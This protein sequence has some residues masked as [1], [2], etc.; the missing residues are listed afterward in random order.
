MNGKADLVKD[1][2][3]KIFRFVAECTANRFPDSESP[4]FDEPLVGFGNIWT[5]QT[6]L[7]QIH[8]KSDRLLV[9]H[10]FL[11]ALPHLR[12]LCPDD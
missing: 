4:Y 5:V 11:D 6:D 8:P 12:L 7:Q 10:S 3:D 2:R 9:M 1:L